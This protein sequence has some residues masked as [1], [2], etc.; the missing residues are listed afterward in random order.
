[1]LILFCEWNFFF[2]RLVDQSAIKFSGKEK[3]C[4]EFL[5]CISSDLKGIDAS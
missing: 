5:N 3:K 4:A 1:M 2:S